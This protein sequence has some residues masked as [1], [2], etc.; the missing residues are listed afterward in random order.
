M[1][2]VKVID[3]LM[4]LNGKL[5]SDC[6]KVLYGSS[7]T[8]LI[9]FEFRTLCSWWAS[10]GSG[11]LCCLVTALVGNCCSLRSQ[12]RLTHSIKWVNEIKWKKKVKVIVRHWSKVTQISK[13]K[14]V[15]RKNIWT[16]WNQSSDESLRVNENKSLYKWVWSHDQDGCRAHIW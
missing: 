10:T 13:F 16:I 5:Y 15:F 2:E 12:S 11:E 9:D 1:T 7:T 6:F 8:F 14:L 4:S 3:L